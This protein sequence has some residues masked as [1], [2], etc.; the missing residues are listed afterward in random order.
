MDTRQQEQVQPEHEQSDARK[1]QLL[2][3]YKLHSQLAGDISN[4]QNTIS[5]FYATL[6]SALLVIFFTSLQH[7]D[8]LLPGDLDG[9]IMLGCSLLITGVLGIL[10]SLI[11]FYSIDHHTLMNLRKHIVL[12]KLESELEFQFLAEE[13][14]WGK[15]KSDLEKAGLICTTLPKVERYIPLSFLILF[16]LLALPG[17]WLSLGH[18]TYLFKQ[19]FN[20]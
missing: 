20:R 13:G 2:E 8:K 12:M 4:R 6:V 14:K 11:W 7:K 17:F 9:K 3:I 5:R 18:I 16:G 15:E 1:N 19:I 10:L